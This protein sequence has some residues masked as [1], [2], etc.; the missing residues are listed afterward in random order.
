MA[1]CF[2]LNVANHLHLVDHKPLNMQEPGHGLSWPSSHSSLQLGSKRLEQ[3]R[4]VVF[5]KLPYLLA[6]VCSEQACVIACSNLPGAVDYALVS[7]SE[8]TGG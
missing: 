3:R 6:I 5:W 7:E 2:E 1:F 4:A 8:V